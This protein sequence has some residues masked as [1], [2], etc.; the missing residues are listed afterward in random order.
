MTTEQPTAPDQVFHLAAAGEFKP[1]T[2]LEAAFPP[3]VNDLPAFYYWK[4]AIVVGSYIHP[5]G[6]FSLQITRD[7]LDG[8]TQTFAKMKT[9]GVNV[10]IL[11]DH[12]TS[13]AAT[14]GWIVDVKRDGDRLMELHQF[15][16][17]T[18][19]DIG[20]RNKVSLGIDPDFVDGTGTRYGEAIV[21][22]AV[23][24]LPVVPNQGEFEAM[25]LSLVDSP[26][27]DGFPPCDH[28]GLNGGDGEM[29]CTDALVVTD[30]TSGAP[31]I[32][33]NPVAHLAPREHTGGNGPTIDATIELAMTAIADAAAAK[34]DL[35][36]ARGA[37]D[38][39]V[40]GELFALLV[41]SN[42]AGVRTMTLSR[43]GAGATPPL[44]L[45]VFDALSRNRPA[46][47][48][49]ITGLQVL[50]RIV[51]GDPALAELQD[52][53]IALASR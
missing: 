28:G 12:N 50:S 34:R 17:E 19:R 10:P 3:R 13:A 46:P 48:G 52:R 6:R 24:P 32:P 26:A 30:S 11:M 18:S 38:P 15:L 35:A 25:C 40:A 4:D 44:A 29:T 20:L 37:I 16:G 2:S 33:D 27:S 1:A 53:M 23:T 49:E 21:H 51:P 42:D 43:T 14:L 8:Y 45:A 41:R 36:V 9:N 39:A 5:Q 7:K 31:K 22:S 47:L